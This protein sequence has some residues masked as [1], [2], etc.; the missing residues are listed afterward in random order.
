[1]IQREITTFSSRPGTS[2]A[3][4]LE[5]GRLSHAIEEQAA[6]LSNVTI[7]RGQVASEFGAAAAGAW[8]RLESGQRIEGDLL[9][10]ADGPGSRVRSQLG[11][12]ST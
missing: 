8:A 3:W 2:L 4:I 5:A 1:M 12:A 6:S 9:V 10:G 11:L 7:L